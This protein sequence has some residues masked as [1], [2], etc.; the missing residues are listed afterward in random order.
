MP[1]SNYD[2]ILNAFVLIVMPLII[3]ANLTNWGT[4]SPTN[5]YLWREEPTLMR[6]SLLIL[7]LLTLFSA[8][9]LGEH[10]GL[11]SHTFAEVAMPVIGVPFLILGMAEI[12]LSVKAVLR[13]WRSGR[14][15]A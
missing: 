10:L 6:L 5:T 13:Y 11:I 4:K 7:G 2:L 1:L 9:Q 14:S 12:W 8:I 15:T 3:V